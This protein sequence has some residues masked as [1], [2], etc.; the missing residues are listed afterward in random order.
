MNLVIL[1]CVP[2]DLLNRIHD[3]RSKSIAL[4]GPLT[5]TLDL[6]PDK[7]KNA[8]GP[9]IR[10]HPMEQVPGVI[11]DV[12]LISTLTINGLPEHLV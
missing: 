7:V 10:C 12:S 11:C 9:S 8:E 5:Y 4:E 2:Y 1:E 6:T 3:I